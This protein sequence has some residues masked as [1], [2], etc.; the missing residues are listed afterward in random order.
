M[1]KIKKEKKAPEPFWNDFV[2][3]FFEF[4]KSK[5]GDTPSFDNSAPRNLK[6]IVS[7]LRKRAEDKKVEWTYEVAT[8]RFRHFLEWAYQDKWLSENWLLQNIDRQKDK[9]FFS[10]SRQYL[11]R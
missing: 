8:S 3:I 5:F 1:A 10:I 4:T 6:N 2:A 11:T 9:V 7:V